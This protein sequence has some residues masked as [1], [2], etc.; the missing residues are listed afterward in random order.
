MMMV[1][2]TIM[3]PRAIATTPIPLHGFSH[4]ETALGL[5]SA[6]HSPPGTAGGSTTTTPQRGFFVASSNPGGPDTTT[7]ASRCVSFNQHET[8]RSRAL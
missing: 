8:I 6:S 7:G 4:L 2:A 5:L 1:S 3:D